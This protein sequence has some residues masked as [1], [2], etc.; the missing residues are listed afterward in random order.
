MKVAVTGITGFVGSHLADYILENE[1]DVEIIGLK[2]WRSPLDNIKHILGKVTLYDCDLTDLPSVI[3]F[4]QKFE[5]DKVFH[6][7]AQSFVPYSY[8]APIATLNTNVIGSANLL[9]A[10]R[11]SGQ[12][13]LIHICS[14]SEVYGQPIYTPID[15]KHP[16]NPISPYGVSKVAEDRLGWAYYKSYGMKVVITRMFTHTGARR[17][18]V[19][20]ASN[21]AKQIAEI[22]KGKEPTVYVGNLESTRTVCDVRDAVRAYWMLNESMA[23]EVYNI[24]GSEVMTVYDVLL[25]LI[26]MSSVKDKIKIKVDESRLRPADVTMQIPNCTKFRLATKWRAEIPFTQT[27]KWLLDY[28]REYEMP[29]V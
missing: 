3:S 11:L 5:I 6:L 10:I 1:P 20:F 2:R 17:G 4:F 14:S 24:G 15:E 26:S 12:R 22:E 13:P 16:L 9:E 29:Q 19:F 7:A 23:G 25:K 27:L 21:F 18:D 28:W 8:V